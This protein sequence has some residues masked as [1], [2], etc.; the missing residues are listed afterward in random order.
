VLASELHPFVVHFA[1]GLL[2]TA[3]ICDV[4]GLLLR[5]EPLLLAGKWMTIVGAV[6]AVL[7]ALTGLWARDA[8]GIHSAAGEA[9]LHLH[10]ALGYG[11]L[12]LSLPIALW[13][14][15]VKPALPLKLRTVYLAMMFANAVA[16]TADATLGSTIVYSHG[17]GLSPSARSEP[18]V[19]AK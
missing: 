14:A 18:L 11:L 10:T 16:V 1:I 2:L 19:P 5:R 6:A 7:S 3:P 8:L 12:G 13:R 17:L 4:L 9:L 15:M